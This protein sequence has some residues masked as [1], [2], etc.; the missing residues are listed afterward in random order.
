MLTTGPEICHCTRCPLGCT[1][2]TGCL[3]HATRLLAPAYYSA[4]VE[5]IVADMARQG[6]VLTV[7]QR[8]LQPLRMGHYETVVSVRPARARA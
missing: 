8:P 7:E 3:G 6:L 5:R 1:P 4:Q 2:E